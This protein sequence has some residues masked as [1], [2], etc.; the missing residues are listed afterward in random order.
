MRVFYS[1]LGWRTSYATTW[2]V[3][4]LRDQEDIAQ[5]KSRNIKILEELKDLDGTNELLLGKRA[6]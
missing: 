1:P 6:L 3:N 2:A 4:H 5:D